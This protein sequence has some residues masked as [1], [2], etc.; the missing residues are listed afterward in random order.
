MVA[1]PFVLFLLAIVL[2]VFRFTDSDYPFG[3][4]NSSLTYIVPDTDYEYSI[5]MLFRLTLAYFKLAVFQLISWQK[6][7][8]FRNCKNAEVVKI[9][10]YNIYSTCIN[11][12][13][14][15]IGRQ[16]YHICL[17]IR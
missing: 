17:A 13:L 4:S 15:L 9:K 7:V 16:Q 10:I 11:I 8:L 3:I 2:F 6:H 5:N 1:F 12:I 14:F